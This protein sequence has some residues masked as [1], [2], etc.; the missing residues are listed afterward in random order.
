MK[1]LSEN[2]HLYLEHLRCFVDE[3]RTAATHTDELSYRTPIDEF[4]RVLAGIAVRDKQATVVLEPKNQNLA[5]RPDWFI[6]RKDTRAVF[7]YVEA[8]GISENPID[9]EKHK[10]Q[11]SRYRELGHNLIITDGLDFIFYFCNSEFGPRVV[12][13]INKRTF[14]SKDWEISSNLHEFEVCIAE[15]FS[16]PQPHEC[17]EKRLVELIALRTRYLAQDIIAIERVN[18]DEAQNDKEIA[19]IQLLSRLRECITCGDPRSYNESLNLGDF[20]S[21]VLMFCL[22]FAHRTLCLPS[23]TPETRYEKMHSF[24][25]IDDAQKETLTPFR[26]IFSIIFNDNTD[27]SAFLRIWIEECMQFL[28]YVTL[29]PRVQ[30]T[31]D[32]HRLYEDFLHQYAPNVKIDYGAFYTPKAL[33]E[34]IVALCIKICETEFVGKSFF[35]KGSVVMDPC[36]GTGSF[37]EQVIVQSPLNSEYDMCGVE[38]LPAP[39]MLA[40]YRLQCIKNELLQRKVSAEVILANTLSDYV[41]ADLPRPRNIAENEYYKVKNQ[42]GKTVQLIVC[43]PPASDN[44]RPNIGSDFST[45]ERLM[46]D[47]RPP[48]AIRGGR[49]NI[50]KQISNPFMQFIRWSCEVINRANCDAILAI[51]VPSDFLST[52]SYKY[53]RKYLL[54]NF[55]SVRIILFDSDMRA[56]GNSQ[57]ENLFQ[58]RQGRAAVVLSKDTSA[59]ASSIKRFGWLDI[60]QQS[61]KDKNNFLQNRDE[62]I[63]EP[64][65]EHDIDWSSNSQF[66][67]IPSEQ[68]D[69]NIYSLYWPV[70]GKNAPDSIFLSQVS[71]LKLS[72]TCLFH[73]ADKGILNRRTRELAGRASDEDIRYAYFRGQKKPPSVEGLTNFRLKVRELGW[74]RFECREVISSLI[75]P[76]WFRPYVLSYVL[77]NDDLFASLRKMKNS[78][79]RDRPELRESYKNS[80]VMG[81]ALAPSPAHLAAE[82]TPF[83]SFCWGLP[84]N[85]LCARGNGHLHNNYYWDK[86]TKKLK[87]NIN[88]R[89]INILSKMLG[90]SKEDCIN[91]VVFYSYAILSSVAYLNKFKGAL[92]IASD[93]ETRPRLPLI[94]DKYIFK[95]LCK[96][97]R[98]L[99]RLEHPKTQLRDRLRLSG[100][101]PCDFKLASVAYDVAAGQV[102]LS[103]EMEEIRVSC[104]QK[105]FDTSISGY[106][107]IEQWVQLHSFAYARKNFGDRE[108]C[109]FFNLLNCLYCRHLLIEHI[110][111][112]VETITSATAEELI[113][114]AVLEEYNHK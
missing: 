9:V 96:L 111:Q 40:N 42:V 4:L 61:L 57:Y 104:G 110:N 50:Q 100:K 112:Y 13:L 80:S 89:L 14:H 74:D 108:L 12:P 81:F 34:Y 5:G 84:D 72:P 44:N 90:E 56:V 26:K 6:Y 91:I 10:D 39:Y 64:F 69:K 92:Y 30:K 45:I 68:Y 20:L 17:T 53:A 107:V 51:V 7:G 32:F 97:G 18:E 78:G 37:L 55:T 54:N 65:C 82:L 46:E 15:F 38:I 29:A 41:Y 2:I 103:S 59:P 31:P 25:Q 60:S 88:P 102:V 24:T 79:M 66:S 75:K 28:S 21:Q 35:F 8:K 67:L 101:A 70:N 49:S 94:K 19:E 27:A 58:T 106:R 98:L 105:V 85:D 71:G 33:A 3:A 76:Y 48:A 23:D 22:L 77:E 73:C 11:F 83:V 93:E 63:L 95:R 114:P 62:N 113:I 99:A 52:P 16:I 109:S 86:K 36:C 87:S 1:N 43:N 47:F